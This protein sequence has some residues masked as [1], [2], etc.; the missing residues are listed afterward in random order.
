MVTSRKN[1]RCQDRQTKPQPINADLLRRALEWLIDGDVFQR[2]RLHGNIRWTPY[3]LVSL[4]V[5]CAWSDHATLTGAFVRGV[6]VVL[7]MFGSVAVTTYLGLTKALVGWSDQLLP[8]LWER[9]H[10]RMEECGGEHWRVGRWLPLAVDGSRVSTPRTRD[11]ERAFAAPNYGKGQT[12]RSRKKWK[13]K[14]RRSTKRCQPVRPQIWVTLLWHMGLMLPWAWKQG[15]STASERGHFAELLQERQ[16]PE[17]TLFC[18]DAG[19]VGYELWT[20]I[21]AAGHHFAI[22]VGANVNLLRGLG[23]V[24]QGHGIVHVWPKHAQKHNQPPLALRLL[25]FQGPRGKVCIVT[26]VLCDQHLSAKAV[27]RLYRMRWGIEL[28]FRAF[29]QTFGRRQLRSRSPGCAA[30]EFDWSLVALWMV[31]LLAVKEQIQLDIAPSRCS[32]AMALNLIRELMMDRRATG[33]LTG[34]RQR[35][36]AAVHDPYRRR[37]TKRG[38]YRSAIKEPPSATRPQV[39]AATRHQREAFRRLYET[40]R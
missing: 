10:Q 6:A 2:V 38:R 39:T 17:N 32:V 30:V 21:L 4:A 22:R 31:Q 26:S 27:G 15:P 40:P 3:Q 8:L 13:N 33:T 16:F 1:G 23:R 36:T 5:V 24:R 7:S 11:N 35:I 29:K 12:A 25:E 37:G 20:A 28:Q 18:A 14:K 9:L 19:F 34:Y